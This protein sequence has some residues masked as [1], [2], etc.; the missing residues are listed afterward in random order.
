[1]DDFLIVTPDDLA[2]HNQI[3][4]EYLEILEKELPFLKLEKCQFVK[5]EI[6]FLGYVIDQGTIY[7]DPSKKH[8]LA[9][10]PHQLKS[11]QE[12]R[13]NLGVLGYQQQFIPGF[14][15]VV[16]LSRLRGALALNLSF[17]H[18]T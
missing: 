10:W 7:I 16:R 14:A 4:K 18:K 3:T 6:K 17:S 15:N 13:S 2:L 8:G 9:D 12:V 11:V 1:L 5:K